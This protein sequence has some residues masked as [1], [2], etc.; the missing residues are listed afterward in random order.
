MRGLRLRGVRW[1][2]G[3][4]LLVCVVGAV[5]EGWAWSQA[6]TAA[7]MQQQQ[8]AMAEVWASMLAAKVEAHQRLLFAIAQGM[9]TSLIEP[10]TVLD[11]LQRQEGSVLRLFDSLYVGLPDGSLSYQ[12][13]SNADAEVHDASRA[14]LARTLAEGKPLVSHLQRTADPAH[15]YVLLS[16]PMR[17]VRGRLSGALAAVVKLPMAGLLPPSVAGS[18]GSAYLLLNAQ[19]QVLVQSAAGMT[20]QRTAGIVQAIGPASAEQA[21]PLTSFAH[22]QWW[23]D[24]LITRVGLPLPQWQVVVVRDEQ[25]DGWLPLSPDWAQVGPWA[26]GVLLLTVVVGM[27]GRQ[28]RRTAAALAAPV[29]AVTADSPAAAVLD[30]LHATQQAAAQWRTLAMLEAVPSAL[31]LEQNSSVML[32]TPQAST[33]LGYSAQDMQQLP[34]AAC[35]ANPHDLQMVQ[36]HLLALGTFDGLLV[37]RK[38][39]GDEVLVQAQ[40]WSPARLGEATVWRLRL[41]WR[42]F[43]VEP[44]SGDV[45]VWR[46]GL[47]GIPNREAFVWGLQSWC[48][49]GLQSARLPDDP[50]RTP[51]HGCLLFADV[52]HLGL[53][54]EVGARG[55]GDVVLRYV[56]HRMSQHVQPLGDVARLGGDEF[57]VL[58]PGISLAHGQ[59]LAQQLCDAL[60]RW[61]PRW[62]GERHWVTLSIGVVAVDAVRHAPHDALRAADM[63]CYEAKRRGRNQVAVGQVVGRS[64]THH[65]T[66]AAGA[67]SAPPQPMPAAAPLL[68]PYT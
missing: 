9:H 66:S 24:A 21:L 41:P 4:A 51:A 12:V 50:L 25:G 13:S 6:R 59:V 44:P 52:D 28:R 57:A 26:A 43:R 48:S 3:V 5:V 64:D 34:L 39:D 11:V 65:V 42:Q 14:L 30:P 33:I 53:L 16:V 56:A 68:P 49:A 63:A 58:L 7:R 23:D 15:L 10:P 61:E 17:H 38:K 27:W 35:L 47:T 62:G 31:V 40:A 54:N 29:P 1:V 20:P 46:D 45:A 8:T 36:E 67:V 37:L 55:L 60:L 19:G 22:T 18:D 2:L 32:A